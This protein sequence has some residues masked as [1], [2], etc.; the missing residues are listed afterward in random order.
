MAS[1]RRIKKLQIHEKERC[2]G[3][4]FIEWRTRKWIRDACREITEKHINLS[5]LNMMKKDIP[6]DIVEVLRQADICGIYIPE[7]YGVFGGGALEMA[8]VME[9]LSRGAQVLQ[10][11]SVQQ[12]LDL[13]QSSSLVMMT[14]R[15]VPSWYSGGEKVSRI[16]YYRSKLLVRCWR[17]RN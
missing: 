2:N 12:V 14:R 5:V 7:E 1:K 6:W 17:Y 16:W 13:I 9:E 10:S 3:W 4:L 11:L 8:I 15:N